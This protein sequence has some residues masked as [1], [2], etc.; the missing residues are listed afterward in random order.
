MLVVLNTIISC[1]VFEEY[2]LIYIYGPAY[3]V[4]CL[5]VSSERP[6]YLH[7]SVLRPSISFDGFLILK[8]VTPTFCCHWQNSLAI[9]MKS[10]STIFIS[11]LDFFFPLRVTTYKPKKYPLPECNWVC[12]KHFSPLSI[13][14]NQWQSIDEIRDGIFWKHC[15]KDI[16]I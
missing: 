10:Y 14:T 2:L 11:W 4:L 9:W 7:C 8:K 15:L 12:L 13:L 5:S 3:R 16:V 1:I 6:S